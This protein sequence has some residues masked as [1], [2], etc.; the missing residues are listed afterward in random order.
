MCHAM[1][2]ASVGPGRPEVVVSA[3]AYLGMFFV[4]RNAVV[5]MASAWAFRL[6]LVAIHVDLRKLLRAVVLAA[7]ATLRTLKLPESKSRPSPP[8]TVSPTRCLCG[9]GL[10]GAELLCKKVTS[11][12][13]SCALSAILRNTTFLIP[14]LLH[15]VPLCVCSGYPRRMRKAKAEFLHVCSRSRRGAAA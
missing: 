9:E 4:G 8:Q 3:H 2:A 7:S 1:R 6:S 13:S 10:W 14:I 11:T 5:T 15:P 12:V